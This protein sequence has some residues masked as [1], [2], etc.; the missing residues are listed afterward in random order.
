MNTKRKRGF[1][2]ME[3]NVAVFVMA[4]GVL[5]IAA[6]FPLGMRESI[7]SQTDFK[8]A[9]FAD[10]VLNIAVAAASS[11]NLTWQ[12][13]R[14]WADQYHTQGREVLDNVGN[15][16][17]VPPFIWTTG[18]TGTGGNLAARINDY[19]SSQKTGF[20]HTSSSRNKTYAIYCVLVPGFSDQTMGILVRS[21]EMN[22]KNMSDDEMRRRLEIQPI[23]Y[24]EARFQGRP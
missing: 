1:S 9:M 19:G 2:L 5:A 23:Y 11:T 10:Y 15:D 3:V 17:C 7:L 21:L 24:A 6:L 12:E 20:Q 4:T 8:Q 22:T 14:R 13:W 16:D 18:D